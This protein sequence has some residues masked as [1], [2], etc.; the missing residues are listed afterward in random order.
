[1]SGSIDRLSKTAKLSAV[2][3]AASSS[4]AAQSP[5][6]ASSSSSA[7]PMPPSRFKFNLAEERPYAWTGLRLRDEPVDVPVKKFR[8]VLWP[9][10]GILIG[11]NTLFFPAPPPTDIGGNYIGV[12]SY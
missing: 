9:D 11:S 12:D 8:A 10:N 2:S 1:M 5:S 6:R 4:S 3:D 7:L